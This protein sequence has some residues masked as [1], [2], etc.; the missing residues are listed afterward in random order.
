M[1]DSKD[2]YLN[3]THRISVSEKEEFMILESSEG[4]YHNIRI[5][6]KD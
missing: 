5:K 1:E 4:S 6:E 3:Y 2:P